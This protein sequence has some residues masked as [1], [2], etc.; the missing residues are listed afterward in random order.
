MAGVLDADGLRDALA[1]LDGWTGDSAA[2]TR[3]AELPGFTAAIAVVDRVASVAEEM[4]HHPD[5]DIRWRT[6]TFRCATH[7]IGGVTQRDIELARRIDEI[8]GGAG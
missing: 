6:L 7:S 1:G 5:I 2:I 4:D 8:V 3:T